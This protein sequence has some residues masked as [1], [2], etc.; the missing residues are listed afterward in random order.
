MKQLNVIFFGTPDFALPTVR[1][2]HETERLLAVVTQPDKPK[3]RGLKLEPPPVKKW[4]IDVG[5]EY[6]Q[7]DKMRAP[8]FLNWLESKRADVFCV[9]A[10]G[11]ILPKAILDMPRFGCINVH[12]SLLPRWRGAAPIN[13]AII[14]GDNTTGI[15]IMQMDEGMDTG[16]IFYQ[17]EVEI[18]PDER[19]GELTTRLAQIGAD[20]LKVVLEKLKRGEIAPTPQPTEGV[21]YAPPIKKEMSK[22]D[23]T[24]DA[25]KIV[26]LIR[27]LYPTHCVYTLINGKRLLIHRAKVYEWHSESTGAGTVISAKNSIIV[28]T[29]KG[30]VELLEVQL[31]GK[32]PMDVKSFLL[33]HPIKV[34]LQLGS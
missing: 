28:K 7:P 26:N 17:V 33:G 5:L 4:A 6:K 30:A 13:W 34:G 22:L 32:R 8:E 25:Q 20:A 19:A 10:Y 21:T 11:K 14:E 9:A 29:G 24:N 16:A 1:A 12:A 18:L 3:G 15:T 2:L 23:W 27:G 31:E